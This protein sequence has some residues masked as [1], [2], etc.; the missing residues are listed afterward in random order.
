MQRLPIAL[1]L[2]AVLAAGCGSTGGGTR[3]EAPRLPR[4]L[5][6]RLAAESDAV[7]AALARG[8]ACEAARLAGR[9]RADATASIGR[10]PASFQEPLSSGVNALVSAVPA[11]VP[12]TTTEAQPPEENDEDHKGRGHGGHGKDG[13]HGGKDGKHGGKGGGD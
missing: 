10:V 5:A 3:V 2:A 11:C 1:A 4:A 8:D 9:L 12:A 7:A 6:Q 13:K